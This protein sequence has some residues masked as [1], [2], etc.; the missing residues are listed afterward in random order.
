MTPISADPRLRQ[1]SLYLGTLSKVLAPGLRIGWIRGPQ[2]VLDTLATT[3]QG[4]S[5][6]TSTID[7]LAAVDWLTH[8]DLD[9]KLVPVRAEYRRRRDAMVDGLD[10]VLPDGYTLNTPMGGMFLW[11]NLPEGFDANESITDAV[12]AGVVYIPGAQF[13]V[14]DPRPSTIRLSFVSNPVETIAEGLERLGTIFR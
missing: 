12:Q 8:N 5:L 14:A 6:Q 11:A 2:E 1:K 13:Y 3:K 7:Q 9:A 4:T 10:A